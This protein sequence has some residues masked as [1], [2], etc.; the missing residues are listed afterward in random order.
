MSIWGN[1]E[2]IVD[3]TAPLSVKAP[4]LHRTAII[5]REEKLVPS[6]SVDPGNLR[7]LLD[8]LAGEDCAHSWKNFCRDGSLD[9]LLEWENKL[10]PTKILF[11]YRERGGERQLV[12]AGAVADNLN[13]S[14]PHAGFCVVGRCYIMPEFR[15]HGFYRQTL[16]HR[17]D[18][19]R[20]KFGNELNAVHI[21]SVNERVFRVITHHGLP[22]W[23]NFIHLGEEDLKVA[24]HVKT[25]GAYLMFVPEYVRKIQDAL[26]G[27][28]APACVVELRNVLSTI[29]S[30]EA[31]NLGPF[32]KETFEE[33][34]ELGWFDER[35][36]H[37][38][39]QLLLFC[40]SIPLVD[41]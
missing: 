31:R 19:C 41:F 36:T 30:G 12:A 37:E 23:P 6:E 10:R 35:G 26:A 33:A 8:S 7:C 9:G 28:D 32:V 16:R 4:K 11:F 17:L 2:N 21:G 18:H 15:G 22:G 24:G 3:L 25:V 34:R 14:F 39:E 38:I 13:H 40:K 5:D 1:F 27:G 29:G 20:A